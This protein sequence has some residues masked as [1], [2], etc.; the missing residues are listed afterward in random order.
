M[1]E[2]SRRI[3]LVSGGSRGIGRA[4]V[5][6]LVR[7]GFEVA[8]CYRSNEEAARQVE[9]EVAGLG[10]RATARRVDVTD[11]QAVKDW[12]ASV[13][14]EH[15]GI[16]AVVTSAGILRDRPLVLMGDEDWSAVI[17]TNL[18]GT[19]N[20]CRAAVFGM[21]KRR[22]GCVVNLSSASGVKGTGGQTNYS[23]SKAGIIGFTN[24]LAKEVGKYGIRANTVAPG[25]IETEMVVDLSG[26]ALERALTVISL[27]RLGT[28]DEVAGAVSYLVGAQYVTGA[29]LQIDGGLMV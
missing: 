20:V 24:A 8:F 19:Y 3:A 10:G 6:Q 28:A 13:E 18:T 5:L 4:V 26:K 2:D 16:D 9:K 23:A 27:G 29:V 11:A 7:D 1:S 12:V 22:R 15:G 25:L 21:L 14:K 17:D